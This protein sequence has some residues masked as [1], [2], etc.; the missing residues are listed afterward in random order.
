MFP[1][2]LRPR[3]YINLG[4]A[5]WKFGKCIII[6]QHSGSAVIAIHEFLCCSS[7][8][9]LAISLQVAA[10]VV[11]HTEEAVESDMHAMS[12]LYLLR[13]R[14]NELQAKHLDAMNL[15]RKQPQS[16]LNQTGSLRKNVTT[17]TVIPKWKTFLEPCRVSPASARPLSISSINHQIHKTNIP[18]IDRKFR[19][20]LTQFRSHE[21]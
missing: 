4:C 7:S 17:T 6:F 21:L 10:P 1:L 16:F 13:R 15:I 2:H 18:C 9:P 11:Q 3:N 5:A 20:V 14:I 19:V 8:F 12:I